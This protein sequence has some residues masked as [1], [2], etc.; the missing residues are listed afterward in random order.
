MGIHH[1]QGAIPM[2]VGDT[3]KLTPEAKAWFHE[4]RPEQIR[5]LDLDG[6]FTIIEHF[7]DM[8]LSVTAEQGERKIIMAEDDFEGVSG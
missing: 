2:K 4:R 3:V 1:E 7:P 6:E 8:D 5:D